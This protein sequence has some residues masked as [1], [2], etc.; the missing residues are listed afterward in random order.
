[1]KTFNPWR[2]CNHTSDGCDNCY[3]EKFANRFWKEG[4]N[5]TQNSV[6]ASDLLNE[7]KYPLN[8]EIFVCSGSDFFIENADPLRPEII[9]MFKKRPDLK[10]LITTKRSHRLMSCMMTVPDNCCICVTMEN[11]NMVTARA[12]DLLMSSAKH[13]AIIVEP[14]LSYVDLRAVLSSGEICQVICGGESGVG[15]NIRKCYGEWVEDLSDQCKEFDVNFDW[16]QT[17]T[18]FGDMI[19][20]KKSDQWDLAKSFKLDYDS[21]T[22]PRFTH[23][24]GN[25]PSGEIK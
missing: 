5:W 12:P 21:K 9:E 11:Q 19:V 24:C 17:G 15:K 14:M 16:K 8:E 22:K 20:R 23:I 13:K 10:F 25:S 1:M 7:K 2:G 3:A 6:K 18:Y 4:F